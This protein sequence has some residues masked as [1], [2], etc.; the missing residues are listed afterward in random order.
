MKPRLS[1]KE[2][3]LQLRDRRFLTILVLG[4]VSGFPWVLHGT[5]LSL[6]M[7]SEG[8]TRSAIGYI[9]VVGSIYAF[10]WIWAPLVDSIRLP[11]LYKLLGQRRS[12]LMLTMSLIVLFCFLMSFT[13]PAD[14]LL[15][16]G[17]LAL[18]IAAA[19]ATQDIVVD[20]YRIN[21][22][23]RDEMDDKIPLASAVNT[24]GWYSGFS[25]IGG[26]AALWL[27]GETIGLS[28]PLVYQIL[29]LGFALFMVLICLSPEPPHRISDSD[30]ALQKQ[31][32][33]EWLNEHVVIP[34]GDF[35]QRCGLKFGFA[36]LLFLLIFRI[37]EAMLG[38]MS[39]IFYPE[40]GFSTDEIALYSRFLGGLSTVIFSIVGALINTRFGIIRGMFIGGVVMASSNLLYALMAVVGPEPWLFVLTLLVDN[41]T[42]A[43][44]VVAVISFMSYFASEVYTGT[45]FALMTSISNFGRTTLSAGS[46]AL[47]DGLGG[48]WMLFFVL[49]TLAVI[50]GLI[51]L[52]WLGKNL[53]ANTV[54]RGSGEGG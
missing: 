12:W 28:W 13:S 48:N 42:Q 2:T 41:F 17:L 20:A 33:S 30:G 34:F 40:L 16:V 15:P 8:S 51:L 36:L 32:F 53:P 18:G 19:S 38:R 31:S 49:T 52:L 27:G 45:Q 5:V 6:W 23:T 37:G 39:I 35:F 24:T 11:V 4:F 54:N 21:L 44:A 14:N 50:P 3:L 26:A 47:V 29:A 22:F 1:S 7:F 25:F 46:G 43:F 10:N 9:G